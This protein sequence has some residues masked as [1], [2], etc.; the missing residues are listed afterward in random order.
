MIKAGYL[1][2]GHGNHKELR[3]GSN[4]EF[5]MST[6]VAHQTRLA[7]RVCITCVRSGDGGYY[8]CIHG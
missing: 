2:M 8:M 7:H 6:D 1:R 3:P 5:K 4:F